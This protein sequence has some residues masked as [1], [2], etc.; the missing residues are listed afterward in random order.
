MFATSTQRRHWMFAGED[1]VRQRRAGAHANYV[2]AAAAADG[3]LP[4]SQYLSPAEA[5]ACRMYY[6]RKLAEFCAKFQP[7]MPRA[8]AGTAVQYFKRFYTRNSVV[9]HH[10]KEV[11]VTAAFLACKVEEFNVS[12]D[13][14]LHNIKGNKDKATDIVLNNELLLMRE[15]DF[16]LTVHNPYRPLE[17]LL[18]DVKTR[19]QTLRDPEALRK[20]IDKFLDD[21][22]F[23]D[24]LL[25]YAPSQVALAA[26]SLIYQDTA[27]N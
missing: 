21:V 7:P 4:E 8:V 23:S 1:A 17:G 16:H 19:C 25:I 13:Q 18:I 27:M 5:E 24:A 9:D 11:L 15:L 3:G 2:E 26:V 20:D 12:M 14:F 22:L 10:P 6:E